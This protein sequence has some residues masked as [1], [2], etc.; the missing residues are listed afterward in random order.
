MDKQKLENI[1]LRLKFVGINATVEENTR[2]FPWKIVVRDLQHPYHEFWFYPNPDI[3]W[4]VEERSKTQALRGTLISVNGL[5]SEK[6][7]GSIIIDFLLD[8]YCK[9]QPL[10]PITKLEQEAGKLKEI[11]FSDSERGSI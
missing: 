2:R 1:V 11:L 4:V 10:S 5:I 7:I 6:S 8:R 3:Y 9:I